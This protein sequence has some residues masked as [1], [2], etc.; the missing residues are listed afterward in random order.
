MHGPAPGTGVVPSGPAPS[1]LAE[2]VRLLRRGAVLVVGDAMLDRY[3]FG[4]VERVSPEA[5]VPVLAVEREVALPGGAGNVVRNLTALSAATAFVSVVGDD[6]AGSDLT[7][8]IGGQAGVEP[9]LLVQGGR[10]TTT[11][12]RFVAAGQQILRADH[13]VVA[14]IHH[15]LADRLIRIATDAVAA[16]KVMVL[17]D[18]GKGVL[19]GDTAQRLITAAQA[20]GRRVVVDPK[21][22]DCARFAGADLILPDVAE[23]AAATGMAVGSAAEIAAAAGAL[24]LAHGFGAVLVLRGEQG[25]TLVAEAAEADLVQH[26]GADVVELVDPAGAGDALLAVVATGLAAGLALPVAA[27]LGALAAGVAFG[28]AG[29]AVVREDELLEM[30]IPG[31]VARRKLASRTQA[32]E[33]VERW[34]RAGWRVGFLAGARAASRPGL[35]AEARGWCDRLVIGL[36]DEEPSGPALAEAPEIDLVVPYGAPGPVELIRLLRPDVLVQDPGRAPE[37]VAGGELLQEWGGTIRRATAEAEP[38]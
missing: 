1:D 37:T 20:A 26:Y 9:W 27:R 13:E 30:L 3:V 38:A 31:R 28:K 22:G 5:P 35:L 19:A 32:A 25:A 21:G 36:P 7:G 2:A 4:R 24:R 15:R 18:Y 17:S 12:T 11:K 6:Q 33:R 34:R 8:L 29:I 16:T 14:P 10:A 23:L